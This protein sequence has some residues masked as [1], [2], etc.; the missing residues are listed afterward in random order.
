M[1][2]LRIFLISFFILGAM[3]TIQAQKV[4]LAKEVI[5]VA[6]NIEVYYFHFTKRC[7][8][9]N[10][11]E[12]ETKKALIKYYSEEMENG[13][14]HFT[15]LN[16]DNKESKKIADDLRLSGQ[17]LL[18]VKGDKHVNLTSQGFMQ[19]RSNPEKFHEIIKTKIDELL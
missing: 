8:T 16:L 12:S 6:E 1:K 15:S 14:I 10:A 18:V 19:A 3:N 4:E 11:V 17:S 13:I 2:T 9:C 5:V 7:A